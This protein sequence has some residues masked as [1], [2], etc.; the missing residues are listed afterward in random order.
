MGECKEALRNLFLAAQEE[1]TFPDSTIN[2][3]AVFRDSAEEETSTAGSRRQRSLHLERFSNLPLA[4]NLAIEQ[5]IDVRT[6]SREDY[7]EYLSLNTLLLDRSGPM[8]GPGT[9]DFEGYSKQN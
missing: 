9:F 2:R 7:V 8:R 3:L 5:P 6:Q 1:V 4:S